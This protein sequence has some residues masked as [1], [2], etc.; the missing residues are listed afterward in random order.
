MTSD[1]ACP[2]V[3]QGPGPRSFLFRGG[4][5]ESELSKKEWGRL[6]LKQAVMAK[7]S[8]KIRKADDS[9]VDE[10]LKTKKPC[11]EAGG[12]EADRLNEDKGDINMVAN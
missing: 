8:E 6:K 7:A 2:L 5:R 4:K 12:H 3:P 10:E 9:D 11:S 1:N